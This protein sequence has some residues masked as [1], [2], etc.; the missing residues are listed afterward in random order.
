MTSFEY[1][2][3]EDDAKSTFVQKG[4]GRGAFMD[5]KQWV[6][7][8]PWKKNIHLET[9]VREQKQSLICVFEEN[10]NESRVHGRICETN[11]FHHHQNQN[12]H[13]WLPCTQ[14]ACERR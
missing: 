11:I 4:Q 14:G 2:F 5:L 9:F 8:R 6:Q 7:F 1:G 3:V 13:N 10:T 12:H